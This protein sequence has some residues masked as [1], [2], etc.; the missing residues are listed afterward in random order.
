M[1]VWFNHW[2]STVYRFMELLKDADKD[3]VIIGS[4]RSEYAVYQTICDEFYTEPLNISENEYVDWCLDFCKKH[5][6]DVFIPR[7]G[8]V[9]LS[10]RL[11]EFNDIGVKVLMDD[12]PTLI[13]K[14]DDKFETAKIFKEHNI[15]KV[16]QMYCV[17]T[18][19]D[20][21]KAY[22][23]I[24]ESNPEDRVCI[25]YSKD[26]GAVSFRVIDDVVDTIASL[27]LGEGLKL[28]YQRISNMLQE[29]DIFED[30]IVMPFLK[31]P[32]IS[33]D[34]LMTHKGF[35]GIC[36]QKVGTRGTLVEY[37]EDI[38]NISKKFAEITGLKMPYNLQLR[39][40]ND[41]LYLLEVNTRMAG[42]TYKSC[43]TGINI[44]YIAYCELLGK[45]F[46]LPNVSNIK[47]MLISQIETPIIL[48]EGL[49]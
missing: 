10:V 12:N 48:K 18:F 21:E 4:S 49:I 11:S 14:L 30:L 25:K 33:V 38:Y 34:S 47:S 23:K 35:I 29:K 39:Y 36:R 26:E 1:R 7:R 28:S 6:I 32:E 40:H 31:G 43:M 44:P 8:R 13:H 42:G 2:F 24:K 17:N 41:E 22:K 19:K 5:L 27:R 16:P 3:I 37:D 20:F 9:E 45:N 46:E 15:C